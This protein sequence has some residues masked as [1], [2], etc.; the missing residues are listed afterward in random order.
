L[1]QI[2]GI[3]EMSIGKIEVEVG[4]GG[5][6]NTH[7]APSARIGMSLSNLSREIF[8][9][10]VQAARRRAFGT[11][12]WPVDTAV[13]RELGLKFDRLD[14]AYLEGNLDALRQIAR[15]ILDLINR[16]ARI[17]ESTG[18]VGP[19]PMCRGEEFRQ[20]YLF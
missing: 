15:D 6:H 14:A 5:A 1:L 16:L 3:C 4:I 20:R 12:E 11:S 2:K 19:P 17:I 13:C 18:S 8:V 9:S 7:N 10:E